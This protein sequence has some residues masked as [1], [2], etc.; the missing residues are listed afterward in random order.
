M[1][2]NTSIGGNITIEGC[3]LN[4]EQVS[5]ITT[6]P[7]FLALIIILVWLLP[8]ILYLIIG[9][10]MK[11]KSPSGTVYSRAMINSPN[12]WVAPLIWFFI[13]G[14]LITLIIIFP[15]WLRFMGC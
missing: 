5:A 13:Q 3:K 9:A 4:F 7:V 6:D 1:V 15:I 12:F 14:V 10:I 11:G 2:A 8:I